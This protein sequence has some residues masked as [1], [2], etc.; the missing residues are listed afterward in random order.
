MQV[1]A[2]DLFSPKPAVMAL[3]ALTQLKKHETL[4][5]L[6]NDGKAV[7]ELMHLAEEHNCGF[8]LEN[9]GDYSVVTLAPTAKVT[10]SNPLEEALHLMGIEPLAPPIF[11]VGSEYVGAGDKRLGSIIANEVIFNI[12]LQENLPSAVIFYNS[13]AK[14]TRADSPVLDALK[15]LV[16]LGVE[17]LT[18]SVSIE[19]YGA[20]D[21]TVA[22]GEI[23]DPY[24]IVALLSTQH[25]VITM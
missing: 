14:L 20:D 10:V 5:V 17:V 15:D 24:I 3:T 9:E 25:G 7:S 2:R 8:S 1:D 13:G 16:E 19:V 23:V 18:D 21:G 11:L 4:A 12:G 22:V 6:V